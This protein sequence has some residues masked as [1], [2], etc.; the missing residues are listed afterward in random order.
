MLTQPIMNMPKVQNAREDMACLSFVHKDNGRLDLSEDR[1]A[2]AKASSTS[3][4]VGS[5]LTRR[6][7]RPVLARCLASL[8]GAT[9]FP[10][11]VRAL[12]L[13]CLPPILELY[14]PSTQ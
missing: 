14:Q 8:L 1:E 10:I 12:L 4:R 2:T 7:R 13:A 3:G 9:Y 5:V 11:L 6:T